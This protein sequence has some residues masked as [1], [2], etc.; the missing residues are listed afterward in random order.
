M[1]LTVLGS[2][3]AVPHPRRSSSS[4]WVEA[5][6]G[7][8]LLD[9]SGP[10]VHRMAEENCD[11]ANLGAV[12][13]SHFHLDHVGGLAPF[14]FGTRHAPQTQ[15]RRKPLVVCGPRGTEKL[16]RRF[17]E[18]GDYKLF[19]QP[20]P[21]EVKE[22]APRAEFELLPGLN[23]ETFSTPHTSES[24]AV[25]LTDARGTSLVYTSDT[26]FTEAL[27][28]FARAADLFL[29]ECSFFREKPIKT[30]LVLEEAMRL[31]RLS[32]ARRV[33]L[34]HLYP[35]WDGVCIEAEAKRLWDGETIEA[36]DGLRLDVGE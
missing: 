2:G 27:A 35:E 31:A 34:S 25:R 9:C 19:E 29:L 23:A 5:A 33:M 10:A 7:T 36:R 14:L 1:R 21:L 28:G 11:W 3:T 18:A 32:G 30:H 15:Q 22:V 26:G 17:D 16:L 4:H 24:L 8:L 12:W 13:I 6:A 20:F